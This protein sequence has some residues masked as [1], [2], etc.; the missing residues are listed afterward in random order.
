MSLAG[1]GP[2]ACVTL[3]QFDPSLERPSLCKKLY[4]MSRQDKITTERHARTLRELVKRPENR[5]CA[6]C[7]HNGTSIFSLLIVGL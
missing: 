6:D 5:V 2:G 1:H 3:D 4:N 7:K